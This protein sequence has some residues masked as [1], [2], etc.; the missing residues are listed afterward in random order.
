M[1]SMSLQERREQRK[2]LIEEQELSDLSQEAFCNFIIFLSQRLHTTEVN[3]GVSK[4]HPKILLV[5][6]LP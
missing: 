1:S 3:F 2:V 5:N 4:K 6:F